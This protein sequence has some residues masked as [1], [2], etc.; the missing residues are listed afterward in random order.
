[1]L[2]TKLETL[3]EQL[4]NLNANIETLNLNLENLFKQSAPAPDLSENEYAKA[5]AK[6]AE[7][8]PVEDVLAEEPAPKKRASKKKAEA[9]VEA[10]VEEP[11]EEATVEEPTEEAVSIDDLQRFVL[12]LVREKRH[13]R[14]KIKDLVQEITGAKFMHDVPA[15][16]AG[17]LKAAI[18]ELA[19]GGQ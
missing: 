13:L 1:M 6:V 9:P 8:D 14:D 15:N 17:E 5:K 16:K 18:E 10:P 19:V 12:N 7:P 4:S 11:T 3:N 2:E